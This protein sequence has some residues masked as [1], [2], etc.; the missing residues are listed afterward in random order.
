M[1]PSSTSVTDRSL[2]VAP[3]CLP[4]AC[5]SSRGSVSV[6][7]DLAICSGSFIGACCAENGWLPPGSSPSS[8]ARPFLSAPSETSLTASVCFVAV[9]PSSAR[10]SNRGFGGRGLRTGTSSANA[11][12]GTTRLALVLRLP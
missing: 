6:A 1:H 8:V 3:K 12:V 10:R 11:G 2:S 9:T 5:I 4:T 7:R